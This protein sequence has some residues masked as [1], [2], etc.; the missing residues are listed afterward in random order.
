LAVHFASDSETCLVA[1][2]DGVLAGF[3]VGTVLEK[4]GSAWTYGY[5]VWLGVTNGTA[6]KGVGAKLVGRLQEIFIA[7]GAR[8]V[9]ADTDAENAPAIAFFGSLGFEEDSE[10]VYLSKNLTY[11]SAYIEHH[12]AGRVAERSGGVTGAYRR[13]ALLKAREGR[14][15]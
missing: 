14:N 10:H 6:R 15:G 1:E 9:L 3:A 4:P 7:L 5:V 2:V 11:D 13:A 12:R 8:M